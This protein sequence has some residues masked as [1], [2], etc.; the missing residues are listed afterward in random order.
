MCSS[1]LLAGWSWDPREQK[2]REKYRELVKYVRRNGHARPLNKDAVVGSWV[3]RQRLEYSRGQLSEKRSR[4]LEALEGWTWDWNGLDNRWHERYAELVMYCQEN[5]H[6][7]PPTTHKGLGTWV[8]TQRQ[9]YKKDSLSSERIKL[10]EVLEGWT[11]NPKKLE[12]DDKYEELLAYTNTRGHARPPATHPSLGSWV[13]NLRQAYRK[14]EL[15]EERV[16]LLEMLDGWTWNSKDQD[17]Y[18][19]YNIIIDFQKS[20]GSASPPYSHPQIGRWVISVRQRYRKGALSEEKI[21][22]LEK[23][24]GWVWNTNVTS[25]QKKYEELIEYVRKYGDA[26]PSYKQPSLGRWVIKQRCL[27]KQGRLSA[28]RI[29]AL[30]RLRGWTWNAREEA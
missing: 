21:K 3:A 7:R 12:W 15:P 1:D 23:I 24:D 20:T 9:F 28:E 10:L 27:K 25:W 11:W 22:M 18:D 4:A 6:A 17:W 19:N 8:T 26:S 13:S 29:N 16:R 30:E 2:W 14:D 5:G